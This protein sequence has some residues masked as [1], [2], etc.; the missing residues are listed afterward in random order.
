MDS[1]VSWHHARDGWAG[2]VHLNGEDVSNSCAAVYL[3]AERPTCLLLFQDDPKLPLMHVHGEI[4]VEL[5]KRTV[6]VLA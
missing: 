1:G 4:A 6:A 5:H 2:T 3:R